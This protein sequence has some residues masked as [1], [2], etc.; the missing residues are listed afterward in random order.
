LEVAVADVAEVE[1]LGHV[2]W[3]EPVELPLHLQPFWATHAL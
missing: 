3:P 2:T 1:E